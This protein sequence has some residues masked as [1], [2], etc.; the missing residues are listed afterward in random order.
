MIVH[1]DLAG[2]EE[3]LARRVLA[4]ARA[5]APCIPSLEDE[6]REDALAII[7]G[8]ASDIVA[9]GPRHVKAQGIG[10]AT[11]TYETVRSSF[12][13]DDRDALRALCPAA[14]PSPGLPVGSFPRERPVS[15]LWPE[16]Y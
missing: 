9:R 10:P 16:T 3:Q 13:D 7:Q 1:T 2:V 4:A 15:Q 5:I 8:I 11:I 12:S 14:S 6:P